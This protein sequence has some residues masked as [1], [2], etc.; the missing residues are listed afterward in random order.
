MVGDE[1]KRRPRHTGV[2]SSSEPVFSRL[3]RAKLRM[4]QAF[5]VGKGY[6]KRYVQLAK[7]AIAEAWKP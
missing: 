4:K 1:V 5:P 7:Q 6:G 2:R 3:F